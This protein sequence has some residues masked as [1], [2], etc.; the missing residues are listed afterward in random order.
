MWDG[1]DPNQLYVDYCN[2]NPGCKHLFWLHYMRRQIALVGWYLLTRIVISSLGRVG[3]AWSLMLCLLFGICPIE[4]VCL[5]DVSPAEL[6]LSREVSELRNAL[7]LIDEVEAGLHPFTQQLLMLEL[8]RLA[9]RQELQIIVATHSPVILES[10]PPEGR[11]FLERT[12]DNVVQQETFRDML[13]RALYGRPLDRRSVL[14]EDE[15]GKAIVQGVMDVLAP[16]LGL[17]AGDL[18]IGCDTGKS[19]FPQYVKA[20]AKFQRLDSFVFVLDGDAGDVE[21]QV[22][23]AAQEAGQA[24]RLLLL[25]GPSNPEQ[26]VWER[27]SAS[28]DRYAKELGVAVEALRT[29]LDQLTRSFE[30]STDKPSEIAKSRLYVLLEGLG[31]DVEG[32]CRIVAREAATAPSGALIE[33]RDHLHDAIRRWRTS[34]G[35]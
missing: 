26:W 8:Q 6:R 27:L 15:V 9:L 25:P 23:A 34:A 32:T 7:V 22:R 5:G 28:C 33:F 14:C 20:L 21:K 13:Q 29:V 3:L 4:P 11:I 1:L 18:D 31:R 19:E 12:E 17:S 24:I 35:V 2:S 16:Q 30:A 10:V